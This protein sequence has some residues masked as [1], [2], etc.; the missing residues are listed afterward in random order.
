MSLPPHIKAK[1][2]ENPK[3]WQN[4]QSWQMSL[5]DMRPP[6]FACNPIMKSTFMFMVS[7]IAAALM[8]WWIAV[9]IIVGILSIIY[10]FNQQ[11]ELLL[12]VEWAC[13]G[14]AW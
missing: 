11:D 13:H 12:Y 14:P 3:K 8:V 5:R 9:S 2:V 10:L 4:A 1:L 7:F 6:Q